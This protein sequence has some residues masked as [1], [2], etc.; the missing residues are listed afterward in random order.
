MCA[1]NYF[2][3]II[4]TNRHNL[5]DVHILIFLYVQGHEPNAWYK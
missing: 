3:N 2:M 5:F 4:A 1:M